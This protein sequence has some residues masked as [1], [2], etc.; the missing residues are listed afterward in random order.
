MSLLISQDL[1]SQ[2]EKIYIHD[3]SW[4][5]E[6][7]ERVRSVFSSEKI[8]RVAKA[9]LQNVKGELTAKQ[10]N[11][12]KRLL[13][14]TPF[15]GHFFKRCPG[16]T[17]KKVL[18]CCNYH[19]LNLGLQC[20]MNCSYCYLQSYINTPTMTLYSN[21]D[22]ALVEL[23]EMAELHS[24]QPFRVGTGE[25]IDS[26]S[27][28]DLSLFSRKLIPFFKKYPKW[29]LEFKTKSAKVD[30]FL[31]LA[32]AG[33]VV[34]SWSINPAYLIEKEEHGTARFQERIEAAKKCRD[35]G[36]KV[37]FHMDPLIYH[38]EWKKNYSEL[39]DVLSSEFTPEQVHIISLGAL[40]FQS[41]QRHM[42]RE[43]FGLSSLVTSA[44]MHQSD[45]GKLRYD[46]RLRNEMF[47]FV[48]G[49]FKNKDPKWN[50][51]LCMETP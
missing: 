21:I 48:I 37:A 10:F 34:V 18:N 6:L 16:A 25:V 28:D 30:Q 9:P 51:F 46:W 29:T 42:M 11:Q 23:E 15:K 4:S 39:V 27:M 14:I 3:E 38:P 13:Y 31:D 43:R 47:Q 32:H 26:L 22:S 50:T 17:Q 2:I 33:N 1:L 36:F 44:E 40:R 5:S 20:N 45:G 19:V 49:H 24:D 35:R 41:D 12:S 8:E 7:A